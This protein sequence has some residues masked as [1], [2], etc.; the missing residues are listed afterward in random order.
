MF[1]AKDVIALKFFSIVEK[2]FIK[3]ETEH[4]IKVTSILIWKNG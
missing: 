2:Y 3:Q 4:S 1:P